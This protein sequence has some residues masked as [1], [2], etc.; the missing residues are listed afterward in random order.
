MAGGRAPE[1]PPAA[2]VVQWR[3]GI[4]EQ[5]KILLMVD[6][7]NTRVEEVQQRV[8]R[9]HP[10]AAWRGIEATVPAFP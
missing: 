3:K 8:L 6:V 5:G 4:T 7:P 9:S 2:P 10:E 1:L